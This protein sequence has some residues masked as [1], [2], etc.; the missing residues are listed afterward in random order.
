MKLI[1]ST[2]L[3]AMLVLVGCGGGE[4][5]SILGTRIKALTNYSGIT[6]Y[7]TFVRPQQGRSGGGLFSSGG[8]L[9]GVCNAAAVNVDEGIYAG[10]DSIYA[11]LDANNMTEM[12]TASPATTLAGHTQPAS[13]PT[14]PQQVAGQPATLQGTE[15]P[16]MPEPPMSAPLT[17]PVNTVAPPTATAPVEV[18]CVIRSPEDPS[19]TQTVTIRNP[20][21]D[22]LKQIYQA[23]QGLG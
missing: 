16:V 10:L 1:S 14:L 2:L 12:V 4:D 21:P 23:N 9:M 3:I 20:S 17:I 11:I 8:R 6:K 22:L 15:Q 19:K 18:I 7:D 5:P 13:Q